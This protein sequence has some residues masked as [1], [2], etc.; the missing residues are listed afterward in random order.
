MQWKKIVH[1][2]LA[3]AMVLTLL[4]FSA[5][6][7][8][9]ATSGKCGDNLTWKLDSAG[10]L[11]ISGTGK[12][13]DYEYNPGAPWMGDAV[14]KAVIQSG[15]T[16]IGQF[17]FSGCPSLANVEMADTVT[18]IGSEA[19]YMARSLTDVKFSKDLLRIGRGA[20]GCCRK[21]GL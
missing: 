14:K 10:T 21:H 3:L 2:L 18:E 8:H 6:T 5:A 9:A 16:Y 15:V 4:P 17:A 11:T 13:Y 1:I 19:F 12:M 7:A 20:F